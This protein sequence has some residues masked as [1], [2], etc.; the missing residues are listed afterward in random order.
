MGDVFLL[1]MFI[2]YHMN[3]IFYR[4]TRNI[5]GYASKTCKNG[6]PG[7]KCDV[8]N[9]NKIIGKQ[10]RFCPDKSQ[11]LNASLMAYQYIKSVSIHYI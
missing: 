4:C 7:G 3:Y 2:L 1:K 8:N 11:A 6:A 10:C 5:Q 9:I